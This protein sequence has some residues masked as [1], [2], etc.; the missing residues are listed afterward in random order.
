MSI[1][2][3]S[4][5]RAVEIIIGLVILEIDVQL[6]PLEIILQVVLEIILS[7]VVSLLVILEISSLFTLEILSL[8]ILIVGVIPTLSVWGSAPT[9]GIVV[10]VTCI[11]HINVF[12]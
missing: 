8:V 4:R 10:A 6:V 3:Y 9:S 12:L 2:E 5:A 7:E 1:F 11:K